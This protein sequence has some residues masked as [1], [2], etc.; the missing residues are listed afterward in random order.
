MLGLIPPLDMAE[1]LQMR[2]VGKKVS[3]LFM[4]HRWFL[5]QNLLAIQVEVVLAHEKKQFLPCLVFVR[6]V[7]LSHHT[8]FF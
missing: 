6:L 7:L 8:F 1:F 3:L 5:I 2:V 4:K